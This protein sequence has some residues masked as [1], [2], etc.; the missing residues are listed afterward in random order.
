MTTNDLFKQIQELQ[1]VFPFENEEYLLNLLEEYNFD[2][3]AV[4]DYL[5]QKNQL[6]AKIEQNSLNLVEMFPDESAETIFNL[7]ASAPNS[8]LEELVALYY[9]SL[10]ISDVSQIDSSVS[11]VNSS[12]IKSNRAKHIYKAGLVDL[13]ELEYNFTGRVS[14]CNNDK[15]DSVNFNTVS[16][17]ELPLP[18]I[19]G[20]QLSN[21]SD[22]VYYQNLASQYHKIMLNYFTKSRDVHSSLKGYGPSTAFYYSQEGYRYQRLRNEAERQ[23]AYCIFIKK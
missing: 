18:S 4:M 17:I 23:A 14:S 20:I 21:G 12:S 2:M 7:A 15:I 11:K 9:E 5:I 3:E 6:D 10:G 13:D 8:T 19:L 1:E 16:P 22:P